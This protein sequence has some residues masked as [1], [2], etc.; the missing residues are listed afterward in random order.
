MLDS[1]FSTMEKSK[2]EDSS[3]LENHLA[4]KLVPRK[5]ISHG[6]F[7]VATR[8]KSVSKKKHPVS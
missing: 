6:D 5:Q 2:I 8:K 7:N 4:K 3:K 1:N